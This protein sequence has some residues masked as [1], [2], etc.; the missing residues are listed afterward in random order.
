MKPGESCR[1]FGAYR[2]CIGIRDAVILFHSVVG[3]NAGTLLLHLAQ[4]PADVRQACTVMYESDVLYGG[5]ET[6]RDGLQHAAELY[7]DPQAIIVISGCVPNLI[8]D[9]MAAA[10]A[11]AGLAVPVL[12]VMGAGTVGTM[13]DGYEAGLRALGA[14]MCPGEIVPRSCNILGISYDDPCAEGDIAALREMLAPHVRVQSVLSCGTFEEMRDAPRAALNIVLGGGG[15]ELAAYMQEQFGTPYIVA[16]Y[17]YGIHGMTAF[18]ERVADALGIAETDAWTAPFVRAAE[19]IVRRAAEPLRYLYGTPTAVLVDAVHRAGLCTFLA[20]ELGMEV[21]LSSDGR[22]DMR[23]V[24]DAVRASDAVVIFGSSYEKELCADE[25]RV[26]V[27]ICYPV[28]DR[29][30][31]VPHGYLGAEGLAHLIEEIVSAVLQHEYSPTEYG[32]VR[33]R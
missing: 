7:P 17:P 4:H 18:I 26:L 6:L 11:D 25:G 23:E 16:D 10:I 33:V 20:E 12:H 19:E 29:L 28:F 31:L 9:E 22:G 3:C 14:Y 30:Q 21:A 5:T 32:E 27:R 1:L 8:G 13:G 2:A 24:Y 15:R